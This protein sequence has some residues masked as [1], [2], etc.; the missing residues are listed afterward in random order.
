MRSGSTIA[1]RPYPLFQI[2][3]GKV[4]SFSLKSADLHSE[5]ARQLSA[6]ITDWAEL[7]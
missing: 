3:D 6:I 4:M 1:R 7:W 5:N 2:T